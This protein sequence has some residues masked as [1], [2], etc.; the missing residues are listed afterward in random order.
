MEFALENRLFLLKSLDNGCIREKLTGVFE[1]NPRKSAV[2]QIFKW[3]NCDVDLELKFS[4]DQFQITDCFKHKS[5]VE[6]HFDP[7]WLDWNV[8]ETGK[9]I[10]NNIKAG[11]PVS[12]LQINN[13][14]QKN[15]AYV[16]VI[17]HISVFQNLVP[18]Q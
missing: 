16:M 4:I 3:E 7:K 14:L 17:L 13:W 10:I 6:F 15:S 9:E 11:K 1:A 8:S 18:E 5:Y 12:V 2:D